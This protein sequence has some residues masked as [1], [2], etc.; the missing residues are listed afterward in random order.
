MGTRFR[1]Y[2]FAVGVW[3]VPATAIAQ[4]GTISGTVTDKA[5]NNPVPS[6]QV[7]IV[8]STRGTLTSD[9]GEYT[10]RAVAAGVVTV[11]ATRIGYAASTQT[12][13]VP[14]SGVV[15]ADFALTSTPSKLDEIVV[16]ASDPTSAPPTTIASNINR[17]RVL[18]FRQC[19]R[20][21]LRPTEMS[22][23]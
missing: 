1:R 9:K 7:T 16:S 4:Q 20:R 15:T 12:V 3:L 10:L 14:A 6:A 21:Q 19:S 13:T 2:A 8:G 5:T 18:T 17:L 11:R 23:G 22:Q